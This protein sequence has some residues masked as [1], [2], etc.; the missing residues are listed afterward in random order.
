MRLI[1]LTAIGAMAPF[2]AGCESFY[3]ITRYADRLPAPPNPECVTAAMTSVNGVGNVQ[4]Q[5]VPDT[6]RVATINGIKDPD[7]R[8]AFSYEYAGISNSLSYTERHDKTT[9]YDHDFGC[10]NCTATPE[11]VARVERLHPVMKEIDRAIE[12]RCSI[13]GM[14]K[15]IR[16]IC[17]KV[18]CDK[19][20]K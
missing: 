19:P 16:E 2:I 4:H 20:A 17:R 6:Q 15:S 9:R 18:D 14:M 11:F 3:G 7:Q 10:K 1:I 12:S 5:F 8:H 13:T